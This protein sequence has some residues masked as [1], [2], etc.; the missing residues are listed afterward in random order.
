MDDLNQNNSP[1]SSSEIITFDAE[2]LVPTVVQEI[3][4]GTVLM[5]AYMDQEAVRLTQETG[6][7]WFWSRS[8]KKHWQKGETSG[9]VQLVKE[10]YF[11][12]DADTILVKVEQQGVACHTGNYSCFYNSLLTVSSRESEGNSEN[13]ELST[14]FIARLAELIRERK[15]EMPQDSYVAGLFRKGD[16]VIAR[17]V[18]E[19]AIETML[20]FTGDTDKRLVEEGADLLF[21]LMV[22]LEARN[23]P[24]EEVLKELQRRHGG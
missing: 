4:T 19:E 7:T 11:D 18:G 12:C 3:R 9:H 8:R 21:H 17:K 22:A 15:A 10:M 6:K 20:A 5:L 16:Q 2:G 14:R 1:I 24:F 13:K 23:V